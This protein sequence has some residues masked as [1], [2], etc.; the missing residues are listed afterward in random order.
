[1]RSAVAK[2]KSAPTGLDSKNSFFF[3]E[4]LIRTKL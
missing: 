4:C 3:G 2:L 1:M